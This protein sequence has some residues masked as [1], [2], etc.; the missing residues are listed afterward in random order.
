MENDGIE[1]IDNIYEAYAELM[2]RQDDLSN[3]TVCF[4]NYIIDSDNY[5]ILKE[6][7]NLVSNGTTG[8]CTWQ[9]ALCLCEWIIENKDIFLNRVI[10][11]LGSGLGLVGL[12]LLRVCQPK[13]MLF[14]DCHDDVIAQ[15][16]EN[17]ELNS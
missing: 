11:E 9:A 2:S 6:S 14:S 8:L 17:I 16:I 10:L 7:V 3:R 5:F 15:L 4:K 12:L 13:M 1:V